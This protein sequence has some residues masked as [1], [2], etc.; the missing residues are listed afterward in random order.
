[1]NILYSP[2]VIGFLLGMFTSYFLLLAITPYK[3]SLDSECKE[4]I[5]NQQKHNSLVFNKTEGIE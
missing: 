4:D 5:S 2:L 1:M 3:H